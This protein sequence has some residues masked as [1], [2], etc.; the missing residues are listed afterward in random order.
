MKIVE[1]RTA[2]ADD[3]EGLDKA[4]NALLAQGYQPYGNPY[5]CAG[6]SQGAGGAGQ[7]AQAMVRGGMQLP[8]DPPQV[9]TSASEIV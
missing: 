9:A 8:L 5:S 3:W 7:L 4:V 6:V 1:Y 2:T